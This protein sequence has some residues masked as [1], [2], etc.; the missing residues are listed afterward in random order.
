MNGPLLGRLRPW[1]DGKDVLNFHRNP[2]AMGV[3]IGMFCG[4]IP[5]PLQVAGS[6][7]L[8]VWLRANLIA[9]AA[10]TFYTNPLTIVPLYMLAFQI[11]KLILPVNSADSVDSF[12]GVNWSNGVI[13][14]ISSLGMPLFVGL[15]ILGLMFAVVAY[16]LVQL[17]CLLPVL[18]RLR[19]MQKRVRQPVA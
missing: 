8:C 2:L 14:G 9:A 12:T 16:L 15:P 18:E 10:A 3:A 7:L 13:E 19:V 11:G 6:L 5:G 1:L 17:V 4:L